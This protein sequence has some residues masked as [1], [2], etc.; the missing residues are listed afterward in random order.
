MNPSFK[1]TKGDLDDRPARYFVC[2]SDDP[3]VFSLKAFGA[4]Y[5]IEGHG[6]AFLQALEARALDCREMYEEILAAGT[7]QKAESLRVIE[8][9]SLFLV[10]TV[11]C[12]IELVPLNKCTA[13]LN[14]S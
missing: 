14:W 5:D 9:T 6:L 10:F 13:E 3:Y 7:A 8:P 12:S 4:F 2:F 11:P 1:T